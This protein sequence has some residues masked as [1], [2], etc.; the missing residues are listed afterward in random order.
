MKQTIN[1]LLLTLLSFNCLAGEAINFKYLPTGHM[2]I[3]VKVND[4]VEYPFMIDTAAG[5][6]AIPTKLLKQLNLGQSKMETEILKGGS[7]EI[8]VKTL[9]LDSIE[10]G[11]H[12]MANVET[13]L[14]DMHR[15]SKI[16]PAVI[17]VPFLQKFKL[18]FDLKQ[19]T[20]TLHDKKKNI[21][22]SSLTKIPFTFREDNFITIPVTVS[23]QKID[24]LFDTGA[25]DHVNFNWKA[26]TKVGLDKKKNNFEKLEVRT[27]S[28]PME[29]SINPSMKFALGGIDFSQEVG[30]SNFPALEHIYGDAPSAIVGIGVFSGRRVIID[31]AAKEILFSE[32]L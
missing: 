14:L 9:S 28:G 6:A 18:D 8:K 10:V 27:A 15:G 11:G 7:G 17:G 20:L 24:A 22:S 1:G 16:E 4:K 23:G 32:V 19:K 21:S 12:K 13:V 3:P 2:Y 31:Y 26:A 25:G 29:I 30:I 5:S